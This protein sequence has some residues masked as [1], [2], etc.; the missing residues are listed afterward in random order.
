MK[1]LI[2][3]FLVN[4]CFAKGIVVLNPACVEIFYMLGSQ[5]YISG[6]A[7]T[8]S[9]EIWP[10]DKVAL[11]PSVGTYIKPNLE[12]IVEINPD[13]VITS[14]HSTQISDDL[15]RFDINSTEMKMDKLSDIYEN[16]QTIANWTNKQKEGEKLISDLKEKLNSLDLS[17]IQ[18]KKAVF[19]YMGTNL[20]SFGKETLVGDIFEF[21]KLN[22]IAT[23]LTGKTPIVTSEFLLE[24]N[25]DFILFV[26]K[27]VDDLIRQNPVLKHTKA[28][29]NGKI[30]SINSASLLRG[31][32]RI[33][34][35]IEKLY[36]DLIK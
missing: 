12:K 23:N 25:P 8:Q 10:K 17:K 18:G 31:T 9:S 26:G 32:P 29:K 24:Q 22:N 7:K 1:K 11:L 2:V 3:L 27:S 15:K 16:I 4:F 20:M 28:Y 33:V 6:I 35:E 13:M 14:F 19:F 36:K 30:L 5:D 21:M 34:Y